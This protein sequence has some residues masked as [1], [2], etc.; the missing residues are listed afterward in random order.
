MWPFHRELASSRIVE[1]VSPSLLRLETPERSGVAFFAGREDRLVTNLHTVAAAPRVGA[2]RPDGQ[3]DEVQGVVGVDTLRDLAVLSLPAAGRPLPIDLRLRP[4][5]GQRAVAVLPGSRARWEPLETEI[6]SVH[7]LTGWLTVLELSRNIPEEASGG[8][9]L[10]GKGRLIGVATVGRADES[11]ITLGMPLMYV[12]PLLAAKGGLPLSALSLSTLGPRHAVPHYS[13]TLLE[14]ASAVGLELAA[15]A[16]CE[17]IKVGATAYNQGNSE[18][19]AEI[20]VQV[21]RCLIEERRDCPGLQRIL[22]EGLSGTAPQ[23]N[24]DERAWGLRNTFEGALEVIER[25]FSAQAALALGSPAPS[26]RN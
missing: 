22:R 21:A 15:L 7:E 1:A 23:E 17:A 12:T 24:A 9:L 4:T 19:C 14:G 16:L 26:M 18:V 25:W 2:R 20:Y 6:Q 13:L 8:P 5:A 10:D 11:P 3:V